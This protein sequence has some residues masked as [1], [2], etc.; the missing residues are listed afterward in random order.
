MIKSQGS[1]TFRQQKEQLY[2]KQTGYLKRL[3]MLALYNF[4]TENNT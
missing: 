2:V 1:P 3:A 4:D